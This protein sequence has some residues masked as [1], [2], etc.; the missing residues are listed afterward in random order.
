MLTYCVKQKK[1]TA[2]LPGSET[3]LVTKN[4]RNAMKCVCS[5]CGATKFR[6]VKGQNGAGLL[7]FMDKLPGFGESRK[8]L[9]KVIPM[10]IKE[11]GAKESF[12]D[13]GSGKTLENAWLGITGQLGK[14]EDEK[15]RKQG[16]KK[17]EN[18]SSK[19]KSFDAFANNYGANWH[20]DGEYASTWE[21]YRASWVSRHG[22]V[23]K[24]GGGVKKWGGEGIL[25]SLGEMAVEGAIKAAPYVAKTAFNTARDVSFH[26][27]RD[28]KLQ[29]KAINYALKKGRPLID[30][31]GS[32][33]INKLADAVAT[34]GFRKGE[35][36]RKNLGKGVDIH[37]AIGKLPKPKGGWTL[38]GHKYTGPYN[39]LD[40]QVRYDPETGEILEIYDP[41][42]G[43]TDAIAMQHDV[44]Y[45]VCGDD[46]KCKHLADRKM[47]KS[48]DAVPWNERQWGHWL[49][50]NMINTKQKVG[51]GVG[52]S[53]HNPRQVKKKRPKIN[54]GKRS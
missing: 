15:M 33:V 27:M 12:D 48:L 44:D 31:A 2:C 16:F 20:R 42:T 50:R 39:D 35:Y 43:K 18:L 9:G 19:Q 8:A 23:K 6:F 28:P 13:F 40:N 32:A 7:D 17:M 3:F 36:T 29:Q 4:G 14:K 30:E 38:P 46:K 53:P 10:I 54:H 21:P 45:S 22:G 34:E 1:K 49:A 52:A 37:K 47:V 24:W 51:L 41:P 26:F 5:E 11:P 25:S